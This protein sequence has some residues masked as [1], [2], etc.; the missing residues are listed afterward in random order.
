MIGRPNRFHGYHS[1]HRA[2]REGQVVR[3]QFFSLK[4]ILN[5]RRKTYRL[6]IVVSRKVSKSAVVR[7]RIRRRI[8]ELVR[9]ESPNITKAYDLIISVYSDQLA[10]LPISELKALL[11]RTLSQSGVISKEKNYD[12]S[13]PRGKVD[14][15]ETTI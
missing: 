1:L 12:T 9:A 2:L 3:G 7:N 5:E 6:A 10:T 4:Y 11:I 8:Y 15:K 14:K 13:S